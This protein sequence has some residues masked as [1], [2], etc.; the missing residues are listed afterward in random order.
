MVIGIL[1][2]HRRVPA[3]TPTYI[4]R[5]GYPYGTTD[6]LVQGRRASNLVAGDSMEKPAVESSGEP[7]PSQDTLD[8]AQRAAKPAPEEAGES[9][10]RRFIDSV[11][12]L[13]RARKQQAKAELLLSSLKGSELAQPSTD[14]Q[15]DST[16]PLPALPAAPRYPCPYLTD[17]EISQY[18]MPLY[19]RAWFVGSSEWL[20]DYNQ[21][22]NRSSPELVKTF[23]FHEHEH[24]VKFVDQVEVIHSSENH[25]STISL[26]DREA[27]IRIHTH[28]ARPPKDPNTEKL[29]KKLPGITLRDVRLAILLEH[30]FQ[31]YLSRDEGDVRSQRPPG[32]IH[33]EPST[34]EEIEGRRS[35][36]LQRQESHNKAETKP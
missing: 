12:S 15:L 4:P 25:H 34:I 2:L 13:Q 10:G 35:L 16:P 6:R 36:P 27:H 29:P 8:D 19:C 17:E 14:A 26:S 20:R 5:Q 18:L 7:T 1:K 9:T 23:H 31:G 24:A 21:A 22:P 11:Y 33:M 28:E 30:V 3:L 32:P